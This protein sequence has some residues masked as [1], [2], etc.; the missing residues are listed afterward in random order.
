LTGQRPPAQV[1]VFDVDAE[2]FL[3]AGGALLARRE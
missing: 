1:E 2:P 3:G